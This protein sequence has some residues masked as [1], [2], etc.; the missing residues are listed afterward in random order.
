MIVLLEARMKGLAWAALG[1]WGLSGPVAAAPP[2]PDL[3]LEAVN[4][5][6]LATKDEKGVNATFIK[7]QVLLDRARF[8]P[9]V[10]D[11]HDGENVKNALRAFEKAR[12]LNE[13]GMLDDEV[14]AKL[15]E[16]SPEP[17]LVEYKIAGED[18]KGPFTKIPDRME[19]QADLDRL[20]YSGPEELLAEKF[21]MDRDLLKALNPGKRFD[22]AGASIVVANVARPLDAADQGKVARIEIAKK[23]R[24]LRALAEDGSTLA[25][26]P[27]S[28][29][30]KDKPAPTGT[31]TVRAVVR[32]PDYTYNPDYAFKGVKT[33][34][35]FQIK[36]G[37]NNPVGTVWIDLSAESF[38]I[39]GSPEPDTVGKAY[40]HGCARLTNWDA[41]ELAHMTKKGTPVTFLE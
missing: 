38:G 1:L 41:E 10:V 15:N 34:E 35:K 9:G 20:G 29:G 19:D 12:G 13:D 37:P 8:S 22:E 18:V 17:V 25:V 2:Q 33:K 7:A 24:V 31:Y 6:D 11:G 4:R 30:S 14:W 21:H 32:N 5:A 36:P 26:Y 3:S 39:H 40:S 16:V 28:I 27:A 23:E